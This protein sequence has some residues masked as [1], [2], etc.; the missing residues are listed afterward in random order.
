MEGNK[1]I[2]YEFFITKRVL[3]TKRCKPKLSCS[4]YLHLFVYIVIKRNLDIIN[5]KNNIINY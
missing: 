5:L 3:T 2:Q 4:L 1:V